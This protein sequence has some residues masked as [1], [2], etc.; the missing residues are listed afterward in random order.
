[1][2]MMMMKMIMM[3]IMLTMIMIWYCDCCCYDDSG[4]VD[5]N[6]F[7]Y[8]DF[9]DDCD[10]QGHRKE[11]LFWGIGSLACLNH[12]ILGAIWGGA[13]SP[14]KILLKTDFTSDNC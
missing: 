6:D 5:C 10:R 8:N 7:E 1:M 14:E 11:K 2:M 12:T 13:C 4:D 9:N 3:T